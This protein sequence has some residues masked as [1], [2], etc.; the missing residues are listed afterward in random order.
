[1]GNR[2]VEAYLMPPAHQGGVLPLSHLP[3]LNCFL[4]FFHFVQPNLPP[5]E[6]CFRNGPLPS[7]PRKM[8]V[9]GYWRDQQAQKLV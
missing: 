1:M 2:F 8:G 9:A 5:R 3:E 7:A 4:T 6:L